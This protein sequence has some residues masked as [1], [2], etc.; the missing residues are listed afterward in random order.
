[1]LLKWVFTCELLSIFCEYFWEKW[2]CHTSWCCR[3]ETVKMWMGR[4]LCLLKS[5]QNYSWKVYNLTSLEHFIL[6]ASFGLQILWLPLSVCPSACLPAR[7]LSACQPW[8]CLRDNLWPIHARIRSSNLDQRCKAVWK[9]PW[10]RSLMFWPAIGLD[11]QGQ[12]EWGGGVKSTCCRGSGIS[13]SA[14]VTM[15]VLC[16]S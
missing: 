4:W 9:A 3:L 2:L 12:I 16:T 15:C 8:A 5:G 10:L 14:F 6:E 11:L 1:M 7:L 13:L